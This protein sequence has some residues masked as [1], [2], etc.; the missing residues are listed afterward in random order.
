MDL[1]EPVTNQAS[2]I[3]TKILIGTNIVDKTI[4]RLK[5]NKLLG[6]VILVGI[7]IISLAT[8]TDSIK[9]VY[10]NYVKPFVNE[11][12]NDENILESITLSLKLSNNNRF[13]VY[14]NKLGEYYVISPTSPSSEEVLYSGKIELKVNS[15]ISSDDIMI[16]EYNSSSLCRI[17]NYSPIAKLFRYKG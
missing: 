12:S 14:V 5:R 4:R 16:V 6:M 11:D 3:N 2:G 15:S 8:F 9:I 13:E 1:F 17:Y 10:E 7:I